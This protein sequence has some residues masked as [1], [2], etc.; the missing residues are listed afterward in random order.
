MSGAAARRPATKQGRLRDLLLAAVRPEFR[1]AVYRPDPA[2]PVF[3]GGPCGVGGC[4]GLLS[5]RRMCVIHYGRWKAAGR[6]DVE[7]FVEVMPISA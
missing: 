4:D 2:D 5:A 1:V 7:V 3:G 6:P